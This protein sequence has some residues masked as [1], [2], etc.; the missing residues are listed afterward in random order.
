MA[1]RLEERPT[2][3]EHDPFSGKGS[4]NRLLERVALALN[5]TL[6]LWKVLKLLAGVTLDATGADRCS[7]FL[8]DGLVLQPTAAIGRRKD[9]DLWAKFSAMGPVDLS[10][11]PTGW[12]RL[13]E[14]EAV[15]ITEAA[16]SELIPREWVERFDLRSVVLVPL[17]V[18]GIPCGVMGV[19]YQELHEFT[20]A[21]LRL[22]EAIGS[23]AGVAVRN[24][25]MYESI[26]RQLHHMRALHALGGVLAEKADA[27]NLVTRLNQLL[28]GEGIEVAGLVFKDRA[29]ARRLGGEEP[30]A[31]EREAWAAREKHVQ[32]EGGTLSVQM[33]L[34]RRLVGA[35][36]VRPATLAAEELSF[37]EALANGVAEVA[38]RGALRA[39]VEEAERERAVAAERGRIASDL[40]DTA[41][42]LFVAIGLLAR[43]QAQQLPP[44]SP[45]TSKLFRLVELADGGKWEI[46][47]A[48]QALAFFPAARRGLPSALRSLAR[49]FQ[50][51]SGIEVLVEIEG[52]DVRLSARMEKALYRVAHE[53]F[54][55]AWRHSRC[56]VIKVQLNFTNGEVTLTIADDGIGLDVATGQETSRIGMASMR[57]AIAEVDGTLRIVTGKPSGT[58][59]QARVRKEYR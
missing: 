44:D 1:S 39:S 17:L 14:G 16:T 35:L 45:W 5:S 53:A 52:R 37:V 32:L 7:V 25:R 46:D 54:T 56:T 36:R 34:G 47:R 11:I 57:R 31:T 10:R 26:E 27:S 20:E 15:P 18:A 43:R 29:L 58:V 6:E 38:N 8:L 50:I 51:D 13:L 49:S 9:D 19:D 40:H 24:A 28:G 12:D 33:L 41:G 22:L 30:T 23:Y 4:D 3:E 21:E 55:N 2:T 59:V 42:Q 48:V